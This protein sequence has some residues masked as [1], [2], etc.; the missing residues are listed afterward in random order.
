MI[1]TKLRFFARVG[2]GCSLGCRRA[3]GSEISIRSHLVQN[4]DLLLAAVSL[5]VVLINFASVKLRGTG[6]RT[7]R[8]RIQAAGGHRSSCVFG[9]VV[10]NFLKVFGFING[11]ES[12]IV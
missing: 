2:P 4:V 1:I 8:P 10:S 12:R 6:G 7:V 5:I 3:L 9:Y 11:L